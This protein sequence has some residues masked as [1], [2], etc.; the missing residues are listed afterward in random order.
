MKHYR[1][2]PFSGH[3]PESLQ[4]QHEKLFGKPKPIV[5]DENYVHQMD[6]VLQDITKEISEPT[7]V[8]KGKI[9]KG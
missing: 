5:G 9:K 7:K 6:M 1:T 8:K 3:T 4:D 2:V